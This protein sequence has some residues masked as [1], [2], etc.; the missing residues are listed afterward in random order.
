MKDRVGAA[1]LLL[2]AC[3]LLA[4]PVVAAEKPLSQAQRQ[5]IVQ[6][7]TRLEEKLS[8]DGYV[9]ASQRCLA[10]APA[11]ERGA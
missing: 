10:T 9:A 11:A 6:T 5:E 4:R 8:L 1:A 2:S 3:F 7:I